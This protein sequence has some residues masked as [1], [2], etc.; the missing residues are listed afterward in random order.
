MDPTR[1]FAPTQHDGSAV[2]PGPSG[3]DGSQAPPAS[4]Q[5]PPGAPGQVPGHQQQQVAPGDA[6]GQEPVDPNGQPEGEAPQ[7]PTGPSDR[8]RQM[9]EELNQYRGTF[10]QIQ[11]WAQQQ[12]A[13]QQRQQIQG[14]YTQRIQQMKSTAENMGSQEAIDYM[15]REQENIT[16]E[17]F[18]H[19]QQAEQAMEQRIQQERR[20]LGTP[21]WVKE[22]VRQSGLP[23]DAEQEL[24]ALGDPSLIERQVPHVKK[25]Y[26]ANRQLQ[27]QL[28]QLSRSMQAGQLVDQG[29]GI[30]GGTVAPPSIAIPED[31]DPDTKAKMIYQNIKRAA[32]GD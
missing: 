26:D 32:A 20:V 10:N 19:M 1:F 31:A 18:Q 24:L 15:A 5:V 17:F 9:E 25:R 11:N 6:T 22:L 16:Q 2:P 14:R 4:P 29:A 21:L 7:T 23:E 8:E 27:E 13:E 3:D 28:D 12:Q 30:A